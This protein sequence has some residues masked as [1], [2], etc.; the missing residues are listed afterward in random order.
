MMHYFRRRWRHWGQ[1][2]PMTAEPPRGGVLEAAAGEAVLKVGTWNM[3]KWSPAKAYIVESEVRVDILAVQ[4]THLASF[5]LECAHG[6]A[7]RVGLHLHHGHPVP[8]VANAVYGRACGVG[9]LVRQGVAVSPVVP[10][11]AAWRRLHAMGRLHAV[12]M[13]PR[14]GLPLGLV[15]MTVYAPLQTRTT[16]VQREQFVALML[17][18]SHQL[19][20]QTPTLLLGDFNG[21]ADP[22]KDFSSA[23]GAR[24]TVCPLLAKLLGPGAPWVD[25]HRVLLEDVPWTF[26][27]VNTAGELSASRIDLVLANHAAMALVISAKGRAAGMQRTQQFTPPEAE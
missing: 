26:R 5:P 4:E 21:S 2:H 10:A 6:T 12:K 17:E 16:A 24:R 23:S 22:P 1:P 11:G 20:M 15:L 9:F 27:N 3:S 25:V 8:A 19:D 18:L 7:R 14:L 13:P